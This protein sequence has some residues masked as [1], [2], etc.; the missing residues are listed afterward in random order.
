MIRCVIFD[1]DDTLYNERTYVESAMHNVA[2][3]LS[4]KFGLN[5]KEVYE[6]LINILDSEGRGHIFD[7]CIAEYGIDE[8]VSK[9]VQV[10]RDTKPQL[11]LYEDGSKLI[12]E[13]KKRNIKTAIITDG[14]SKVQH[15]KISALNLEG[16]ID[17]IIVTDDYEG[18]AKPS[19][20]PYEMVLLRMDNIEAE[21]CI[22]IGDNPRKD[23]IGARK[24]GMKTTRIIRNTGDNMKLQAEEGF[25]ADITIHNL[26]EIQ[27]YLQ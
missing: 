4:D 21:K 9:L 27:D 6:K 3:Y 14:C 25:E 7:I 18:A 19:T 23:F 10:Y 15:N 22:Y 16:I 2:G 8:K 5:N 26:M 24:T 12:H 1:L 11:E 17:E 20:I 13:L